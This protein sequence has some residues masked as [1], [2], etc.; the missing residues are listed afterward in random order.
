V[1]LEWIPKSSH[2]VFVLLTKTAEAGSVNGAA[3]AFRSV[4]KYSK[5]LTG[6]SSAVCLVVVLDFWA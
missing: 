6:I 5:L 4:K 1:V 2:T 3:A